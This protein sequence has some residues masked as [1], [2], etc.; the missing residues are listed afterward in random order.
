MRTLLTVALCI[1]SATSISAETHADET[2]DCFTRLERE[3]RAGD[4]MTVFY[5][6]STVVSGRRPI[7]NFTSSLL[8]MRS[9]TDSGV[10]HSVTIPFERISKITYRKPSGARFGLLIV[11]FA[12]GA[13]AGGFVGAELASDPEGWLDFSELYAAMAGGILGGMIGAGGGY[14]I[15]KHLTVKVTLVCEH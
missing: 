3:T 8:Y 12:L 1:G 10:A 14:Q 7:I 11:G 6:D 4:S 13:V 2:P 15:G 9:V 5:D